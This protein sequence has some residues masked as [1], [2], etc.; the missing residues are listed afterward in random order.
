M[1][2]ILIFSIFPVFLFLERFTPSVVLSARR[3]S[4]PLADSCPVQSEA[5]RNTRRNS[6]K[7]ALPRPRLRLHAQFQFGVDFARPLLVLPKVTLL[8]RLAALLVLCLFLSFLV[9]FGELV[10]VFVS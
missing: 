8:F 4:T 7:D 3:F 5:S 10:V 6:E 9:R 1:F 2:C